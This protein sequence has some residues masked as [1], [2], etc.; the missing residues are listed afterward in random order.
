MH[1]L[2]HSFYKQSFQQRQNVTSQQ[3]TKWIKLASK[4]E[5]DIK[6]IPKINNISPVSMNIL[7][8]PYFSRSRI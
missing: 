4:K 6:C 5:N 3:S 7:E 1:I 2:F 8:N